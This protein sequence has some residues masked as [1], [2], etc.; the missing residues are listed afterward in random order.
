MRGLGPVAFWWFVMATPK[1]DRDKAIRILVDAV[2]LGDAKACERHKVTVRTLQN[3]R[4]RLDGNPELS[5]AFAQKKKQSDLEWDAQRRAF[6]AEGFAKVRELIKEAGL[7]NIRDVVGALKVAGEL[8]VASETLNVGDRADRQGP[9]ASK[10][11]GAAQEGE[12]QD[13][14]PPLQ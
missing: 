1:F 11:Q 9:Q 14:A 8:Q 5:Q 6:L 10:S 4:K 13:T 7:A 12:G 2:Q 3:Y